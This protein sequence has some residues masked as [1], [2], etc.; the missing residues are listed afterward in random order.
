M[1]VCVSVRVRVCVSV[2][3]CVCECAR[4]REREEIGGV[5]IVEKNIRNVGGVRFTSHHRK[6]FVK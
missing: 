5:L 6:F 1:N 4:V 2:R 3:E